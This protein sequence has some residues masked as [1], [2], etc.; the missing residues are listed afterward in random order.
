LILRLRSAA[1]DQVV[2]VVC[3]A[4]DGGAELAALGGRI[5]ALNVVEL[6]LPLGATG[7]R[8]REEIRLWM[9]LEVAG[10]TIAR[11]PRDGAVS[12]IVPWPGWEEENW[13]A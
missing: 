6:S 11:V 5:G 7:A 12:V 1:R 13:S 10:V 4:P 9:T 3:G 2:R 8:P